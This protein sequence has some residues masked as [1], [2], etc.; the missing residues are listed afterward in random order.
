MFEN[1][2]AAVVYFYNSETSQYIG[3]LFETGPRF[4]KEACKK[5]Y[6]IYGKEAIESDLGKESSFKKE[7][8][9]H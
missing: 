3:P 2:K 9:L 4:D 8:D 6:S 5:R 1:R 7:T